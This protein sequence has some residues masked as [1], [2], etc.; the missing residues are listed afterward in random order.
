MIRSIFDQTDGLLRDF[1]G[2]P[3]ATAGFERRL[4]LS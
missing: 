2:G 4:R 3:D 1:A